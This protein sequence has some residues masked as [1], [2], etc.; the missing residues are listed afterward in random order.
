MATKR[1]KTFI[2]TMRWKL[3]DGSHLDR[4][5]AENA[6]TKMSAKNKVITYYFKASLIK[7][8]GKPEYISAIEK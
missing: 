4:K 3:I 8:F 7:K 2:V 1:M 6:L 5:I